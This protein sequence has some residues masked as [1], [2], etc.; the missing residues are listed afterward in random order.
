MDNRA[1][2][3]Q[4]GKHLA[5]RAVF[6]A[7]A[8]AGPL[9]AVVGGFGQIKVLGFG[10]TT[11]PVLSESPP[12]PE[13]FTRGPGHFARLPPGHRGRQAATGS[14]TR[15]AKSRTTCGAMPTWSD[16]PRTPAAVPGK[17]H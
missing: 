10:C 1:A 8:T 3:V 14:T 16:S 11:A 13:R 17:R 15:S 4:V 7:L 2:S 6:L 12:N 9:S 5:L